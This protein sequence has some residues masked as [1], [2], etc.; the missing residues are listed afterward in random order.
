MAVAVAAAAMM[1][2]TAA[3]GAT[4]GPDRNVSAPGSL[5]ISTVEASVTELSPHPHA[6]T[7]PSGMWLTDLEEH[8]GKLYSGYG[9]YDANVGPIQVRGYDPT[10]D[11]WTDNLLTVPTEEIT[12][13]REIRGEL[14]APLTDPTFGWGSSSGYATTAGAPDGEW[15]L[16]LGPGTPMIHTFDVI[17]YGDT[18]L[19]MVGSAVAPSGKDAATAYYSPDNGETW[20]L[21]SQQES[22]NSGDY[23]RYY[24]AAEM[25][26]KV[27][28]QADHLFEGDD[29]LAFDGNTVTP[30]R[31]AGTLCSGLTVSGA[32]TFN[33]KI[34]CDNGGM[35]RTFDGKKVTSVWRTP[36]G[37]A[38]NMVND[39]A[40]H[41][42]YLYANAKAD[43]YRTLDGQNWEKI[44]HV[45]APDM[46]FSMEITDDGTMY[47][48]DHKGRLY[49]V[50]TNVNDLPT[51]AGPSDDT[52][53]NPGKGNKK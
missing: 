16:K 22:V 27:Y 38:Y 5:T 35:F 10:T 14:Y 49:R 43:I 30:V 44:M 37:Y 50:D 26:G 1:S 40:R 6:P 47:V 53:T 48:G 15:V 31:F 32:E 46:L 42:G 36:D 20:E 41:G 7:L 33:G 8:D 51:L 13:I 21:I 19:V 3:T 9:D 52:K 17:G 28:F 23:A 11:T 2:L 12:I 24:W 34:V 29:L 4:A 25:G 45:N 39:F 18:G